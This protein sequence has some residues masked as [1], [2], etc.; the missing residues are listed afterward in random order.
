MKKI[1]TISNKGLYGSNL[2]SRRD[3]L[4]KQ[5][6]A[7]LFAAAAAKAGFIFPSGAGAED[8]P[9]IAVSRGGP[10]KAVRDA[11][12]AL[13]GM[14]AFVNPG[15]RVVIKPN[16][17]FAHPPERATNTHPLLVKALA[18]M[19]IQA[20]ASRVL[21]LDNP[22]QNADQCM[23]MSGI[24]AACASIDNTSVRTFNASRFFEKVSLDQALNMKEADVMR[25]VLESDVLIAAPVAK[26]HSGTGVSLSMKGMM[27]L[28]RDRGIMHRRY[29][30]SSAIVDLCTFLRA[31]L[32][33]I[34]ATRVLSSHGPF[35]PGEVIEAD[36]VIASRDM[37][38]ADSMAVDMFPWYGRDVKP[39]NVAHISEAHKRGLGRMD[40]ENLNI[41]TIKA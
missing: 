33:I 41:K 17:S 21:V 34:D 19:C 11:V 7:A 4:K 35:G 24:S 37:V 40:L 16:M 23:E 27:G 29:N 15:D 36:R 6:Q 9:D 38:A 12:E 1:N 22:L 39:A 13:G 26:S 25:D 31:D 2:V 28:I 30:L 32:A 5:G 18:E 8:I 10:D 20:G 14:G 3:F